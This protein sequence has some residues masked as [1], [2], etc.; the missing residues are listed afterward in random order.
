MQ[1]FFLDT[2]TTGLHP[3]AD[4]LVEIAIINEAGE[5]LLDTLVNPR[6]PIGFATKIHGIS[7]EMVLDAPTLEDLWPTI[8]GIIQGNHVVIYNA[9]FDAKFFPEHLNCAAMISCAMLQ[10]APIFGQR[11]P[12]YEDH[13]WQ[14]LTT[15]ADYI[16]YDWVGEPHRALA[17]TRATRAL[18]VWMNDQRLTVCDSV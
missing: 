18:W 5:V 6:R 7:D 16:G 17:D 4:K 15:A 1:T 8:S 10:F 12:V 13:T 2:E 14:K 9:Q 3:P 11:H